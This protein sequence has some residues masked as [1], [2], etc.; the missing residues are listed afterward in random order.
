MDDRSGS[1]KLQSEP[2]EA[3]IVIACSNDKSARNAVIS[4][5]ILLLSFLLVR[6]PAIFD[7][8]I[9]RAINDLATRS[10]LFDRFAFLLDSYFTYS[11][12]V[13]LTLIW[14]CWFADDRLDARARLI[15][16]VIAAVVA[17]V[18]SRFL[19]YSLPTHPRPIYD[20]ALGY[21]QLPFIPYVPR[22]ND[23]S[24]FP[25]DHA[26][27]F[28]GLTLAI[29][30][31]GF[32]YRAIA[33]AWIILVE[34]MRIVM[35]GHYPTDLVAGG[36]LAG[37]FVWASQSPRIISAGQK[38]AGFEKSR[39]AFFYAVA[40]FL[41]YQTATLIR[42]STAGARRAHPYV[43]RVSFIESRPLLL[44]RADIDKALVR[45]DIKQFVTQSI[46]R[47]STDTHSASNYREFRLLGSQLS[48]IVHYAIYVD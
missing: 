36:A 26:T 29:F 38:C 12:V 43:P 19:Q 22:F 4:L 40:F 15:V 21:K 31:S 33:A 42:R 14:F 30:L 41:S 13:L 9:T 18:C 25:S 10:A 39:P 7:F 48:M 20:A 17:G 44:T 1:N 47:L 28:L 35:G 34:M 2:P 27:V 45:D 11:G 16:G 32:R 3:R 46:N 5:V 8:P 37:A 24:S 6:F 23:W